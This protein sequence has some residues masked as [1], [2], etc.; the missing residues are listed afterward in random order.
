MGDNQY[1]AGYNRHLLHPWAELASLGAD[2]S[3]SVISRGQGAYVY[4]SEGNKLLD[5]PGGMWCMQT[6]YGR[7][8]IA[9]AVSQQ[10]LELGYSTAFSHIHAK[11]V[12]LATRIAAETPGDLNRVYFTTGG[13]TAVD[14]ALRLCQ[15]ASNI[16]GQPQ[17]KHILTRHKAYHGSTYLSASVSGKERD[18]TAMDVARENI[19]FLTAPCYFY[20]PNFETEEQFC[21][22]LIAELEAKIKALGADN[23]MCFIGEPIMASGGV[24]VPPADYNY[25]CW[26]TVKKY[27]ITYIADEVVTGFGRLGHWF[28]SEKVFNIVP[29]MIIFAKG[30]TS[31][32][33]P[34]GGYAVSTAWLDKISGDNADDCFYSNGYTWSGSPVACAAALASWDIV[35]REQLLQHVLEI[36]PYFQQQLRTLKEIPLVGDVRGM[37]LMASV[38]MTIQADNAAELLEKD[39]AMGEM[40]DRHCQRLG[41]LVR[42]FINICIISPPLIINKQQVDDLVGMLR[43]GIELTL[44]D[45]RA[46][47]LWQD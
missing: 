46:E 4:D 6:G 5:G 43:Q 44:L 15:L 31:G 7:K 33:V 9:D 8:E 12:E 45:L 11:E 36:G 37:G 3:T 27:G 35:Q 40:V 21:D 28:A 47:G 23:I 34:M 25:R 1:R 17:R 13:S 38:E 29:D 22:Y 26:Q 41:L 16:K 32:Y 18:K 14:A 19:H 2:T 30:V 10:I 24:I 20:H 42:P 39:Y